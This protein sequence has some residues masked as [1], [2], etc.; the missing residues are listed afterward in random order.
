MSR[1]TLPIATALVAGL[2][3]TA[4]GCHATG[5]A[6]AVGPSS[7]PPAGRGAAPRTAPLWTL[8]P[9]RLEFGIVARPGAL[10]SVQRGIEIVLS[11]LEREPRTRA[12]AAGLRAQLRHGAV[13]F[14]DPG[15]LARVGIDI[16]HPMAA[17][18]TQGDGLLVVLPVKDRGAFV[19]AAGGTRRGAVDWFDDGYCRVVGAH[20]LCA[21]RLGALNRAATRLAHAP[22]HAPP[23]WSR[24]LA[25]DDLQIYASAS[26]LKSSGQPLGG[27]QLRGARAG[28]RFE[29][30]AV[31]LHLRI[32]ASFPP[33]LLPPVNAVSP[34][35][36]ELAREAPSG[37]VL[38]QA[39]RMRDALHRA[40][41]GATPLP[42]G[43][44][45]SD[46]I[47]AWTGDLALYAPPADARV[48]VA[49]ARLA[50]RAPFQR[51]LGACAAG[52]G[53]AVPG[54]RITARGDHCL[55]TMDTAALAKG[56]L[57][58]GRQIATIASLE[59]WTTPRALRAELRGHRQPPPRIRRPSAPA[60]PAPLPRFAAA[61]LARPWALAAWG[62]GSLLWVPL[63]EY[64]IIG[65]GKVIPRA[66]AQ[67]I[68]GCWLLLH[69][70][71]L[72][73]GVQVDP[74]GFEI[75]ARV[76]TL[77]HGPASLVEAF[78]KRLSALLAGDAGAFDDIDSILARTPDAQV[79]SD[80]RVGASGLT[81]A[82]ATAALIGGVV[83][84]VPT[85]PAR[86]P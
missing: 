66:G 35:G 29:P 14:L 61:L 3:A 73:L 9:P 41:R 24:E 63:V 49:V 82:I 10:R 67:V 77:W 80:L 4:A 74:R 7:A 45:L 16:D 31:S 12:I 55:M 47:D 48:L 54:L 37:F 64:G 76:G 1:S 58:L 81:L 8:A 17:F 18:A 19:T 79:A 75:V 40:T 11:S 43:P 32:P 25:G 13:D 85:G 56:A 20:Y 78:D 57:I 22:A 52:A 23:A 27:I 36:R 39:G 15:S 2:A 62:R 65:P 21:D 69:L 44:S 38:L 59:V 33:T 28:L 60:T 53:G 50:N 42:G 86:H 84:G 6:A 68:T 83:Y 26:A 71:R 30:D 51:L 72:G 5:P 34:L 46:L 70:T